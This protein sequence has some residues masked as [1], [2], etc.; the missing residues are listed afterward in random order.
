MIPIKMKHLINENEENL[1]Y[2]VKSSQISLFLYDK[3]V[4]LS[5]IGSSI[6]IIQKRK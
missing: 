2:K 3:H 6:I 5:N 4:S 1:I